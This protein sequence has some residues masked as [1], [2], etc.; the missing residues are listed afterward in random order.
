MKKNTRIKLNWK[1]SK[2]GELLINIE[3]ETKSKGNVCWNQSHFTHKT[4]KL[5]FN[6]FKPANWTDNYYLFRINIITINKV[7]LW[8]RLKRFIHRIKMFF[9][10]FLVE[11]CWVSKQTNFLS[12]PTGESMDLNKNPESSRFI[13]FCGCGVLESGPALALR[14]VVIK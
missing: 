5:F 7:R 11:F 8:S 3:T 12:V 4:T 2:Q 14:M 13:F 10:F 1:S 6:H 9:F